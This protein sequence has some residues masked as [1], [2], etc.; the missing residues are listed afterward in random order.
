VVQVL[1]G[2]D[3]A[4]LKAIASTMT[5]APRVIVALLSS[6]P[7]ASIVIARSPDAAVDAN[8]VLRKVV[9]QFGGRGGGKPDLAQG[10][11][12]GKAE[13][14]AAVTR[15]LLDAALLSPGP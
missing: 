13:E 11:F 9:E 5:A 14:V 4:G 3:N 10:G 12:S 7:G 15:A 1:D 2:W 8:A 6:T